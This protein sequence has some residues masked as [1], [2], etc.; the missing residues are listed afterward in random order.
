MN[1]IK[2]IRNLWKLSEYRIDPHLITSQANTTNF[3][4]KDF[5]T[6]QKKLATIIPPERPEIFPMKGEENDTIIK[7]KKVDVLDEEIDTRNVEN[8]RN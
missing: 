4:I 1:L 5:P 2:R 7:E 8:P 6:I 3:L